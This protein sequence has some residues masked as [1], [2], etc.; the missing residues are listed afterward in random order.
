MR[1]ALNLGWVHNGCACKVARRAMLTLAT[2]CLLSLL[3]AKSLLSLMA[4]ANALPVSLLFVF[5][6]TYEAA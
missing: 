6:F 3:P 5:T 4:A 1:R 2:V